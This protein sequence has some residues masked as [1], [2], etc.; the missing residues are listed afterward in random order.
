MK[1]ID[2]HIDDLGRVVLPAKYRSK[3]GMKSK[4]KV[5]VSLEENSIIITPITKC[6]ALCGSFKDINEELNLCEG[7]LKKVESYITR[8]AD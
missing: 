3:L 4:S 5:L 2:K 8:D 1:G 6:C 7:C